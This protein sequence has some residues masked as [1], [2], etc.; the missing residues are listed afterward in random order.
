M[1]GLSEFILDM[2]VLSSIAASTCKREM[3]MF[4]TL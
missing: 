4:S 1:V 2:D 3:A